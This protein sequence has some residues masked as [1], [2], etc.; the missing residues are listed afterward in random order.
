MREGQPPQDSA[1]FNTLEELYNSVRGITK[2]EGVTHVM[3][4]REFLCPDSVN[5]EAQ[6]EDI[7]TL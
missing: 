1:W 4:Q 3:Q 5:K 6:I 2:A 7:S